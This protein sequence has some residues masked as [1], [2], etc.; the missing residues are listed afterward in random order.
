MF[1]T[2]SVSPQSIVLRRGM[3]VSMRGFLFVL[4]LGFF[5][6]LFYVSFTTKNIVHS[7]TVEISVLLR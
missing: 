6:F 1:Q 2:V 3:A 7:L 4:F 5:C